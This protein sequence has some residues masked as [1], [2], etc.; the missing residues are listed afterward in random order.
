MQRLL[1]AT[2][3]RQRMTLT[4]EHDHK[5]AVVANEHHQGRLG[6]SRDIGQGY[7]TGQSVAQA[8]EAVPNRAVPRQVSLMEQHKPE[9]DRMVGCMGAGQ[10]KRRPHRLPTWLWLYTDTF[11]TASAAFHASSEMY[12]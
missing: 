8:A 10:Y 9:Q 11:S 7:C 4:F 3:V 2:A 5:G 1:S 6:T 12:W